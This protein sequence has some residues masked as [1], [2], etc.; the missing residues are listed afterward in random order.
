[1][2]KK[3]GPIFLR[4]Q[5]QGQTFVELAIS[6]TFLF[7]IALAVVQYGWLMR[8][9]LLLG[10]AATEGA[11]SASCGDSTNTV[12]TRMKTSVDGDIQTN[13]TVTFQKSTDGTNWSALG[14][15]GSSNDANCGQYVRVLVRWTHFFFP[16]S[17]SAIMEREY[18]Q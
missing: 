2:Q 15:S 12:F 6:I 5:C 11:R 1:M 3:R 17:Q 8:A 13:M 10:N 4:D 18:T 9:S 16:I 7:L 14:D